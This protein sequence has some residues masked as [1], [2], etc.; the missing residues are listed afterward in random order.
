LCG[1]V[2]YHNNYIEETLSN[3]MYQ[4]LE[5]L[6]LTKNE[7]AVYRILLSDGASLAGKI[8]QKTGIHRR[9]VYD[10]LERL[11]Q[12]GLVGYMKENNR[13]LYHVTNPQSIQDRLEQQRQEVAAV[14]PTMLAQF[15]ATQ[16][17]KETLFFRG[18]A[19]IRQVMEDQ[20]ASRSEVLVLATSADV[21]EVVKYFFPKYQ[22]LRKER[23]IPT[24]M[25]FDE[26]VRGTDKRITRLP[27]ATIRYIPELNRSPMAQY[28]YGDTVAIVVWSHDPIAIL[29]RQKDIAQGFRDNFE[30]LWK[31]GKK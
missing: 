14:L 25:L 30:L 16:E 18:S 6:G 19:G 26:H 8:T 20:L 12:K 10:C 2:Y 13:K 22:L 7:I 29:I 15:H 27:L 24:R 21:S 11:I 28:I 23:K 31:I 9:N 17:K 5:G 3:T 1:Y 4:F